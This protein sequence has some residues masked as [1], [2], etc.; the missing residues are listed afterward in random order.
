[1]DRTLGTGSIEDLFG[2]QDADVE[3]GEESDD[4]DAPIQKKK[5]AKKSKGSK[6]E[7]NEGD[8]EYEANTQFLV[9]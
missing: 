6:S 7:E 5:Q 9:L 1:M 4:D 3:Q 2:S 8:E